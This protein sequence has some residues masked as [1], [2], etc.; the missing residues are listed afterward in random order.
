M[1]TINLQANI[2]ILNA[3]ILTFSTMYVFKEVE[4]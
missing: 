3:T 2:K 4:K 1:P